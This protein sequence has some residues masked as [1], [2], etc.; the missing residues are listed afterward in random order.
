MAKL[1]R[2]LKILNPWTQISV[3]TYNHDIEIYIGEVADVPFEIS[4][5]P[6]LDVDI[7]DGKLSVLVGEAV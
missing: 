5:L 1:S 2:L 3:N 6:L 4:L 7:I